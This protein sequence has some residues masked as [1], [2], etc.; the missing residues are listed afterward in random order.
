MTDLPCG[1]GLDDAAIE[2][3]VSYFAHGRDAQTECLTDPGVFSVRADPQR[4]ARTPNPSTQPMALSPPMLQ[5]LP[6]NGHKLHCGLRMRQT[7]A[8]NQTFN[9]WK[10]FNE[11]LLLI[12]SRSWCDVASETEIL[13]FHLLDTYQ[14]LYDKSCVDV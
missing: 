5:L 12:D 7:S 2:G 10:S 3:L 14:P 9:Q 6:L 4:S 8:L 11:F 1:I 13:T